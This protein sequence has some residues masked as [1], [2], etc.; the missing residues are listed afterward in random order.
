[1]R[2]KFQLCID[3]IFF[4][5]LQSFNFFEDNYTIYER[6]DKEV[7]KIIYLPY[8]IIPYL[9]R[10]RRKKDMRKIGLLSLVML[11]AVFGF[12]NVCFASLGPL[13]T[14]INGT[15]D[16]GTLNVPADTY[17]ESVTVNRPM[18]IKGHSAAD[19]FVNVP[20]TNLFGF[21]IIAPNVNLSG[22]TIRGGTTI[23]YGGIIIG[24]TT[25]SDTTDYSV[26]GVVVQKCTVEKGDFGI[27]VVRSTGT[28]IMN[29]IVRYNTGGFGGYGY[30]ILVYNGGG[31]AYGITNTLISN[32]K[33]YDNDSW[34]IVV[35][36]G[37]GYN[38]DG[39]K[40]ANNTLYNNGADDPFTPSNHNSQ[41]FNF[42]DATGVITM[43][44]NKILAVAGGNEL[45]INGS[46][47]GLTGTGNKIF[48]I[49][50]PAGL[51][52]SPATRNL[53]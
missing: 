35:S 15:P 42:T 12:A 51:T 47:P 2:T 34:G 30:G 25:F 4:S 48:P 16:G 31:G 46:V 39:T 19:T 52:G 20:A 14:M 22:F 10:K 50:K 26:S 21:I 43:T 53:P 13:Q 32:N 49:L 29:N 3:K 45:Q 24:G 8:F 9:Q 44:G 17:N 36:G 37:I 5:W 6:I 18:T 7:T 23:F 28:K 1:L 33:I 40:L 27:V 41:G 11:L 38:L